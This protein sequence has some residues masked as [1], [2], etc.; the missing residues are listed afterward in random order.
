MLNNLPEDVIGAQIML[1]D[2]LFLFYHEEDELADVNI[3]SDLIQP[4]EIC[5]ETIKR[6]K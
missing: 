4:E 5:T 3:S 2:A 6:L 1:G